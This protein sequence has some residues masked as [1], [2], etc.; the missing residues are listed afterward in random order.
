VEQTTYFVEL[1]IKL[2]NVFDMQFVSPYLVL[3]IVM[4]IILIDAS[5][6]Y[7]LLCFRQK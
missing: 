3:F 7:I 2:L 1:P 4:Q 5:V 6:L